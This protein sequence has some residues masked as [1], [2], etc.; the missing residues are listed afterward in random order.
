MNAQK[1]RFGF[2]AMQ[3]RGAISTGCQLGNYYAR[4]VISNGIVRQLRKFRQSL[5]VDSECVLD[6]RTL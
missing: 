4:V 2:D 5:I 1:H 6:S 3:F